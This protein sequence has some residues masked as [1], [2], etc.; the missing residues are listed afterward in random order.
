MNGPFTFDMES[1]D[2]DAAPLFFIEPNDRDAATE[3]QRVA[4]FRREL[5]KALPAARIIAIPNAGKRGA[6]AIRTAKAEGLAKG[7]PDM[8]VLWNGETVFL[9]W[10]NK[11]GKP[12]PQQADWLNWLHS[13]GHP[14]AVVR[15]WQGA[16][17]FLRTLGWAL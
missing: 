4:L 11:N 8:V 16:F 6:T 7:A 12:S 14:C 9:E 17:G 10:K 5:R 15:S 1:E 2:L 13:N 3:L